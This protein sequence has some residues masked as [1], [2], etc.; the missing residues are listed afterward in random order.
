MKRIFSLLIML[1]SLAVFGQYPVSSIS[2][3]LPPN[4]AANTSDW[5]MP[6]VITAQAK[7]LQ[8]QV[9]G[10]LMESRILVTIK[11]GGS[12]I[13]GSFTQQTAPLSNFNAATKSWSGAAGVG[14]LGSGCTLKPGTYELCVQFF[15]SYAPVVPLSN[16]VCKTFTIADTKQQN[17]SPPQNIIPVNGKIFTEQEANMPIMFRWTPVVPKPQGDVLYKVRLIEILPGQNKTEA[18]RT[19][20]P[21]DIL[22]VK[23]NTQVSYKLSKRIT[24]LYWE[25][26]AESAERVQGEKPRSYGK[27]EATSITF[28]KSDED[29]KLKELNDT[30]EFAPPTLTPPVQ[31]E[32]FIV[33]KAPDGKDTIVPVN[34]VSICELS[35]KISLESPHSDQD[36]NIAGKKSIPF[37]WTNVKRYMPENY[38]YRVTIYNNAGNRMVRVFEVVTDESR[39]D[40]ATEVFSVTKGNFYTC[41][42]AVIDKNTKEICAEPFSTQLTMSNNSHVKDYVTNFKITCHQPNPYDA[43]GNVVYDIT[44]SVKDFGSTCGSTLINPS[45][46]P[47]F[48][49]LTINGVPT[50][51]TYSQSL[52]ATIMNGTT[53]TAVG[54]FTTNATAG[55]NANIL[56]NYNS[57]CMG[58]QIS[59]ISDSTIILPDCSCN[60]CK[61][62]QIGFTPVLPFQVPYAVMHNATTVGYDILKIQEKISVSG[63][64]ITEVK[65]ELVAFDALYSPDNN[66]KAMNNVRHPAQGTFVN[67]TPAWNVLL[68]TTSWQAA[69]FPGSISGNEGREIRWVSNNATGV[70]MNLPNTISMA[71]GIPEY[72]KNDCCKPMY[73]F[74]FRVT[75]RDVD[76]KVC[77]W[78]FC[79]STNSTSYQVF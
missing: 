1:C 44:F 67:S 33:E 55:T 45:L 30:T 71:I 35:R 28:K 7:L 18:L 6:F 48:P 79:G 76:C 68:P 50:P 69:S 12:K 24:G 46:A 38:S 34:T 62:K 59:E 65:V 39:Y 31:D 16:E 15:S 49:V 72:F 54:T 27:S 22:E 57:I 64:N 61:E 52:L 43:N 56:V 17:Y 53:Q 60:V 40:I 20:T 75:V 77:T 41:Q 9:P 2:I 58:V 78:L 70:N 23:N 13:C 10:N 42:I 25:V 36:I 51:V 66:C 19:N 14:L 26:E 3:T 63:P 8:G 37:Y 5:A 74:C 11:S 4:P 47:G 73:K 29:A 21:I 32:H